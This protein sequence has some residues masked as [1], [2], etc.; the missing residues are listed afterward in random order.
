MQS[1]FS[2]GVAAHDFYG[3]VSEGEAAAVR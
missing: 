1:V 3:E 2:A